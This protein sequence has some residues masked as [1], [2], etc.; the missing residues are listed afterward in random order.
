M[1]TRKDYQ[2]RLP[3]H[4]EP[5]E[6][7]EHEEMPAAAVPPVAADTTHV[8]PVSRGH[9][10]GYLGWAGLAAFAVAVLVG[11]IYFFSYRA[12]HDPTAMGP[13]QAKN[14]AVSTPTSDEGM[15]EI[16]S[17]DAS[18]TP[19][20][21]TQTAATSTGAPQDVVYLFPLNG[22]DI[23]DDATLNALAKKVAE[24]GSYVAVVA[25]TDESG[26]AAYNQKLSEQ[27]AK[28]V[29]KYLIAHGV[30]ANHVKT[31]GM[32]ETHA[33]PTAAQDRRAEIHVSMQN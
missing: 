29:G 20:A 15:I 33:Y 9:G 24:T 4:P 23:T 16:I 26:N 1:E 12:Q 11:S 10:W 19:I 6:L 7:A 27:R 17:I 8:K 28:K 18:E 22:S 21:S 31:K 14:T 2:E 3:E 13:L 5:L 30:P 25:Y 32:G